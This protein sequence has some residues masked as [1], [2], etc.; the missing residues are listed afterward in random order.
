MTEVCHG[1]AER[2]EHH[3]NLGV[4]TPGSSTHEVIE[5][6]LMM[7]RSVT[8]DQLVYVKSRRRRRTDQA[9]FIYIFYID[10]RCIYRYCT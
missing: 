10:I 8:Q 7:A 1:I 3:L 5:E 2:L 4:V 9:Y 6:C